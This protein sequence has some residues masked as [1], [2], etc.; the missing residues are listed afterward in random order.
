MDLK[1]IDVEGIKTGEGGVD[2]GED[3][4]AGETCVDVRMM[5]FG[6]SSGSGREVY[7]AD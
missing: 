2:G 6:H 7:L 4:L 3:G 5:G 1:E